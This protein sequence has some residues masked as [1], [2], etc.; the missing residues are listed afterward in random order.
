MEEIREKVNQHDME[1]S[2]IKESVGRTLNSL[3]ENTR[4][5]NALT[6]QFAGYAVSH[7]RAQQD[8]ISLSKKIDTH[9]EAIAAMKPVV[10][11]VRGLVWKV[12]A[13]S[14]L[15]GTGVATLIVALLGK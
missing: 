7:E 11:G 9:S 10:D 2:A 5:M 15:G 3:D 14:L 12:V 8:I 13:A 1:I 6:N 4:A